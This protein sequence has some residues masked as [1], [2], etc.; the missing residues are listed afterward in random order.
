MAPSTELRAEVGSVTAKINAVD[1][2]VTALQVRLAL[3]RAEVVAMIAWAR[4][5]RYERLNIAAAVL[6][7]LLVIGLYFKP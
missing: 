4:A 1:A 6:T 5:E 3:L 7:T 2:E